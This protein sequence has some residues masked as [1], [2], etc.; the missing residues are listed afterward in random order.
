MVVLNGTTRRGSEPH[1]CALVFHLKGAGGE[2]FDLNLVQLLSILSVL[3]EEA[4]IAR[5]PDDWRFRLE[6]FYGVTF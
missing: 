2:S 6:N 3:G 1:A 4:A 5:F